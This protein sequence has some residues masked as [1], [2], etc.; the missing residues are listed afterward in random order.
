MEAF[1]VG[2][3]IRNAELGSLAVFPAPDRDPRRLICFSHLRWDFVH[4]RPQHLMLRFSKDYQVYFF[5]EPV[6]TDSAPFL[7]KQS[8]GKNLLVVTPHLPRGLDPAGEVGATRALLA[9]LC[10]SEGIISP[11]LWYYSPMSLAFSGELE[12]S[13][14]VYDCM[15]QL[16]A[17]RGAPAAMEQL[18]A[19]CSC[20]ARTSCS[21]AATA[22][23]RPSGTMHAH[24]HPFPSSVDV[25][26]FRTARQP[27]GGAGGPGGDPAPAHRPLRRARRAPGHRVAGGDRGYAAAV[28]VR[29]AWPGGEDRSPDHLPRRP[30]IHYLGPEVLS[31][32]CRHYLAGWDVDFHAVCSERGDPLHQ[33]DQDAGVSRR[34][35]AGGLDADRRRRPRPMAPVG[36]CAIAATPADFV[37][38][39]EAGLAPEARR[40]AW[41]E[42]VDRRSR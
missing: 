6:F 37:A 34:R 20:S 40:Q 11:V 4:Q 25:A 14:L 29:A 23:T 36:W 42:A 22:C 1:E 12:P 17:F 9:E 33:P 35:Q 13:L 8:R 18:R 39:L 28:A 3:E 7:Q 30:N 38:A 32:S 21:P 16:A 2:S 10:C 19:A 27:L 41:L 24:V 31:R 5:E 26:H 15:D